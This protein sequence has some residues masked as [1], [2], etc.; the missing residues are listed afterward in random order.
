MPAALT[1]SEDMLNTYDP[2]AEDLPQRL[3]HWL[4][5]AWGTEVAVSG[6]RRFPS[7]MS[8][9]TTGFTA[10]WQGESHDLILRV[11]DPLGLFAPYRTE[12]EFLAL[13][14][15]ASIP[16]L[17]VPRALMCCDDVRVLGA[18]F[19][20][21]QRMP[22][23]APTPWSGAASSD[24]G[25][26]LALG[27]DFS[28]ALGALHAFDWKATPL[29]A[30]AQGIT[31]QTTACHETARWAKV[32]G[33]PTPA[34]PAAL[35][36]AMRWLDANAPVSD[37]ITVVHG[38]YRVGNFLRQGGRITAILDWELVHLGDPHE[39]LAWAG[40]RAFSP[41]SRRVG[42][43]VDLDVF[44]SRYSASSGF[45]VDSERLRY[46]DVLMQ[47]KC[48]AMLLGAIRRVEVG[49]T[50]DV[51]MAAMG[52]QLAPTLSELMRLIEVAS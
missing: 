26:R 22:G 41:G 43:L 17:P 48:A 24:E 42:G 40:L 23:D 13:N 2:A 33:Y 38:D 50:R 4:S 47:F 3:Q 19:V 36:Y 51:R 12:P 32:A 10:T 46:Y 34:L 30:W 15:L 9:I 39:D 21:T 14:V 27:K 25:E 49:R 45:A 8:W 29:A 11:G 18:P 6:W 1:V 5:E 20:V 16:G 7:G 31:P 35:H 44:H 28:D 52:F 37:R